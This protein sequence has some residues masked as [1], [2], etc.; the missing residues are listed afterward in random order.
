MR[1]HSSG[2]RQG[3]TNDRK[4]HPLV[5]FFFDAAMSHSCDVM[6]PLCTLCKLDFQME[7]GLSVS[8]ELLQLFFFVHSLFVFYNYVYCFIVTLGKSPLITQG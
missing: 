5:F 7:Q 6:H 8:D 2:K 3:C 1:F 4:I